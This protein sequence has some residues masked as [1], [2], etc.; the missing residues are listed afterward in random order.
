MSLSLA[1]W[2]DLEVITVV[3]QAK[4]ALNETATEV[5]VKVNYRKKDSL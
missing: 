4:S 1:F 2:N 5:L 3:Q